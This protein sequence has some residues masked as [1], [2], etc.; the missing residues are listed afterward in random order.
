[1]ILSCKRKHFLICI[2]IVIHIRSAC[3]FID[4]VDWAANFSCGYSFFQ[5][6]D[7]NLLAQHKCNYTM[8]KTNLSFYWIVRDEIYVN[9]WSN[10]ISTSST[11]TSSNDANSTIACTNTASIVIL[12]TAWFFRWNRSRDERWTFETKIDRLTY[13]DSHHRPFDSI[14]FESKETKEKH[15]SIGTIN[16]HRLCHF[17]RSLRFISIS[18]TSITVNSDS[19]TI[20][21]K[22][23]AFY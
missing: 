2:T 8:D 17:C 12:P 13:V 21:R 3:L 14:R 18:W 22:S 23:F 5:Y 10:Q 19:E 9:E 16:F 11:D 20:T 6:I 15:E 4:Y 7:L 1:M